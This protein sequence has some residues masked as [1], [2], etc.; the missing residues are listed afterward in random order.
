MNLLNA[1]RQARHLQ[2][3]D[4]AATKIR[5][6]RTDWVERIEVAAGNGFRLTAGAQVV[7]LNVGVG[8]HELDRQPFTPA[9]LVAPIGLEV[10]HP[11]PQ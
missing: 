11:L 6:N 5:S 4:P 8:G 10:G 1:R 7:R 9:A 3:P 2:W